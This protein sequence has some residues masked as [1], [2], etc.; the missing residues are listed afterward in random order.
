M[1]PVKLG[2]SYLCAIQY[3]SQPVDFRVGPD[4]VKVLTNMMKRGL[5]VLENKM[6]EITDLGR[7]YLRGMGY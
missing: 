1:T 3:A 2:I 6:F 7:Q 4:A 5:I